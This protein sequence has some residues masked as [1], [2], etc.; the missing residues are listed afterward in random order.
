MKTRIITAIVALL[1]FVPLLIIGGVPFQL[2]ITLLAAIGIFEFLRMK[3][4]HIFSIEGMITLI[5]TISLT[6]SQSPILTQ[7]PLFN[8]KPIDN[9]HV[10]FLC[11]LL[12][13]ILT[14]YREN[15]FSIDEAAYCSLGSL[16]VG[17]GFGGVLL[18]RNIG[19]SMV[20]FI[21]I[22][23]WSTDTFAYFTGRKFGQH[24]LAP[25]ISPNKTIEGSIGGTLCAA[26]IALV[27]THFYN[28]LAFSWIEIIIM[29]ICISVFG[30]MGD[31]VESAYK[32][33]FNIKDSG[34]LL[35]GHGGILDRFDSTFFA[36]FMFQIILTILQ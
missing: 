8:I 13:M 27:Y 19:I 18:V 11:I 26:V 9:L 33:H 5:A 14:V 17:G 25:K 22:I 10:F 31:L 21:F 20:L 36:M 32:R 16:Y 23:I 29:V 4:I 6:V 1:V 12:L 24:K 30:Q 28:L 15:H 3:E 7:G 34:K 35:P 2:L